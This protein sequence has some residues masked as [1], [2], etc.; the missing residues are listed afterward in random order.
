MRVALTREVSRNIGQCEL[1][2]IE[3][4]VI[5][6][7]M[8]VEQHRAYEDCLVSLGCALVRLPEE[9]TMPDA[10]FVEDTAVVLDELA[11]ITRPGAPARRRETLAVER[12]LAQYRRI[13]AIQPPGTLDGGDVLCVGKRV[14]VGRSERTNP[15]AI[16]QIRSMLEPYDYQVEEVNVRGCLHLKSAV[17]KV[18]HNRLLV[19]QKWVDRELFAGYELIDVDGS[20]PFG[21]NALLIGDVV[22]YPN[23]YTRTRNRL[24][25]AGVNVQSVELSEIAKAEGGVTCCSLIF[26]V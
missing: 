24:E 19:N 11:I 20:E 13:E 5:D 25:G 22:I 17:S 21:A 12:T 8:A 10:V 23:A 14:F 4:E 16:T 9:P 3:R 26:H 7:E 6:P 15:E 2:H 1:S 18:G